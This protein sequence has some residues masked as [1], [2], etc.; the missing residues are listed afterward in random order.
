MSDSLAQLTRE[1]LQHLEWRDRFRDELR[2]EPAAHWPFLLPCQ[3]RLLLVVDGLD[4]SEGDF[5][6]S[7]FVRTLLDTRGR[8]VRFA[9]TL[10]HLGDAVPSQMM[11]G[12]TRIARRITSFKFDD[13]AHFG[14]GMYDAVWLF[15][16]ATGF[17]RDAG[18]PSDRLSDGELRALVRFMNAGGGLFAT[19]DHGRLGRALCHAVPRA[20]GMRRWDS[21]SAQD[22]SDHVAML[23]P[24]RNDTNRP[25]GGESFFNDQ[26]DDVP[27]VIHPKLYERGSGLFR[28][29]FPHPLLCGPHGVIRVM[30]DHPHEGEC[31]VPSRVDAALDDGGAEYPAAIDGGA[32]PLPEIIATSNVLA[33]TCSGKKQRTHAQS[34]GG[35][36]AYDGHRAGVGRVVTDATWH[37]FV[38]VNLVGLFNDDEVPPGHPWRRGFL[39]SA[40]GQA[41]FEQI[42]AYYRNLGLWLLRPERIACINSRLQWSIVWDERVLEA[43]LVAADIKLDRI[44]PHVLG[45]IGR[46]ARDVLGRYAGQCQGLRIVLDLIIPRWPKLVPGIDPWWDGPRP[47]D[48]GLDGLPWVDA[49][50]LLDVALGAALVALREAFPD[51]ASIRGVDIEGVKLQQVLIDGASRGVERAA[52]SLAKAPAQ[53]QALLDLL[54][55][56]DQAG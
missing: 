9:I 35:I 48:D 21:T 27:Q 1:N 37:H 38:N 34:F 5:G 51:P 2:L 13:R 16:I 39:S 14:T 10:A 29:T 54:A 15:G 8:H 7:T 42:K 18:Y 17:S 19:G 40:S 11:P 45:W 50:P 28:S 49:S 55:R 36:C 4:F 56:G 24:W 26:S 12:D 23:G 20:R 30:P 43:V 46:H 44:E 25:Q 53:I 41:H 31:L 47:L 52:E 22:A 3:A 33:G 32:R 6:L